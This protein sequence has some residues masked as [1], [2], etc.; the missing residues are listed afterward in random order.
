MKQGSLISRLVR[1]ASAL[2]LTACTILP[3]PVLAAKQPA[4][5][6]PALP[7]NCQALNADHA[8]LQRGIERRAPAIARLGEQSKA[9]EGQL[10]D[11]N[12]RG[13]AVSQKISALQL[14][15]SLAE[16]EKEKQIA[17]LNAELEDLHNRF[18]VREQQRQEI[19]EKL[20]P[21]QTRDLLAKLQMSLDSYAGWSKLK[22]TLAARGAP[23][24]ALCLQENEKGT[25]FAVN[26][27]EGG[28][29]TLDLDAM[30]RRPFELLPGMVG[31]TVSRTSPESLLEKLEPNLTG[32]AIYFAARQ[33]LDRP[34][35]PVVKP[36][37]TVDTQA[38]LRTVADASATAEQV[39]YNADLYIRTGNHKGLN[40]AFSE[41]EAAGDA[42]RNLVS[43]ANRHKESGTTITDT[44]RSA[45]RQAFVRKALNVPA[46]RQH[47]FGQVLEYMVDRDKNG[48][49][50]TA[51][52]QERPGPDHIKETIGRFGSDIAELP[53]IQIYESWRFR[54]KD[55]AA[56]AIERM[57]V[58][59]MAAFVRHT[60]DR[61]KEEAAAAAEAKA[62]AEKEA[63]AQNPCGCGCAPGAPAAPQAQATPT[64]RPSPA[65][66]EHFDDEESGD[67]DSFSPN[68]EK[69][70]ESLQRPP[71]LSL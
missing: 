50:I 23:L 63:Q 56:A 20:Y 10:R 71:L 13:E 31:T 55:P 16:T 17:P 35:D 48:S 30:E 37:Y 40:D 3:A 15:D 1:N 62:K 60:D 33:G 34:S 12:T 64:P 41:M 21:L 43:A 36:E 2:T 8:T 69:G 61:L 5:I 53:V 22:D 51:L 25:P 26:E 59:L 9:L 38:L 24:A 6:T 11:I 45:F 52:F 28:L 7:E 42:L 54:D 46:A 67:D 66:H 19:G 18:I 47:A 14:K 68:P 70:L 49:D 57:K 4:A 27:R 29:L 32:N 65:P 58:T 39:L 44:E